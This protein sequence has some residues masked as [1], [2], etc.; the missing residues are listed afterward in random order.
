M[1]KS[2]FPFDHEIF[3]DHDMIQD[4]TDGYFCYFDDSDDADE[5]PVGKK[6][7]EGL[8]LPFVMPAFNFGRY[9]LLSKDE[10]K[11][12]EFLRY[13][14]MDSAL[15]FIDYRFE[16]RGNTEGINSLPI[17][18]KFAYPQTAGQQSACSVHFLR[19]I[20]YNLLY[21]A[22]QYNLVGKDSYGKIDLAKVFSSLSERFRETKFEV[23][24]LHESPALF[25][26]NAIKDAFD[27][28]V[29]MIFSEALKYNDS[30]GEAIREKEK[31]QLLKTVLRA[32]R[33]PSCAEQDFRRTPW[34]QYLHDRAPGAGLDQSVMKDG[35]SNQ[36]MPHAALRI[37]ENWTIRYRR[38]YKNVKK[39]SIVSETIMS[40]TVWFF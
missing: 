5:L 14:S 3:R 36:V 12:E 26:S 32:S 11:D 39:A 19:S 23:E 8:V 20:K 15:E 4:E 31:Q 13:V 7:D 29:K 33:N 9:M 22:L 37:V 21:I 10:T 1:K 30:E 27:H 6:K 38:V 18:A 28:D 17:R 40:R 2:D 24:R 35:Q 34:Q 25:P 16:E